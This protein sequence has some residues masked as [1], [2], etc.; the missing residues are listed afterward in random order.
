[1]CYTP[2]RR[3]LLWGKPG[4]QAEP[5]RENVGN[6]KKRLEYL[7]KHNAFVQQTY[8]IVFSFVL[9]VLGRFVPARKGLVLLS[10]F[11]GRQYGGSPRILFEAMRDDPRFSSC[12]WVWAFEEPDRFGVEGCRKVRMDSPAYYLAALQA[13]VWIT[14]V[15]I[16]RGLHFKKK[17]TIY[18][19]T[20]HGAGTK[21]IGNAC[22]G[23]KDYDFRDV[24]MMLVQSDF[25]REIFLRDFNCNPG[26]IRLFGFPRND[27]L[28]HMGE[29]QIRAVRR[30]LD[31]PEDKRVIL[32]A[33]TWRDSKNGGLS[34][35]FD[36]PI[37]LGHW[38]EE[39]GA[40]Y[41]VLFRTHPFTTHFTVRFNRFIRDVTPYPN[42][43]HLLAVTDILITDYSTIVY[44][45]VIAKK[46][47][48]CFGFDYDTYREE[49]GFYFDLNERYP[50]GVV[51]TEDQ[52]LKRIRELEQG[53]HRDAFAAFRERYVQA[54]GNATEQVMEELARRLAPEP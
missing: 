44:D 1:M 13:E 7:I 31:I 51:R 49:R 45:C 14:S 6:F 15:N 40:D 36:P 47:F 24:D 53:A 29:E 28:F 42:L 48:I 37:D 23:R 17:G 12:Q 20:W 26:A 46:P 54:G 5:W 32:Y 52:L 22:S 34:Y 25:E 18:V 27:E 10:D 43:N 8:K 3:L 21:K 41:V 33:P 35:A 11:G 9:R 2:S 50:G 38:E 19:N 30:D 4:R 16:E 39:L